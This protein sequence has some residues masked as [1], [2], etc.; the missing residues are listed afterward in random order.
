MVGWTWAQDPVAGQLLVRL[1][2]YVEDEGGSKGLHELF[3]KDYV[4]PVDLAPHDFGMS[5]NYAVFVFNAL[6]MRPL[7][8]MTGLKGPAECLDM[9]GRAKVQVAVVRRP[10]A[11][12]GEGGEDLVGEEPLFVEM[13]AAF[14]IH[15]SHA[16][17]EDGKVIAHFSGWPPNDSESFLGAWGGTA[18][19]FER[20]PPTFLWRLEVDLK[21]KKSELRVAK[22]SKDVCGEHL[23]VRDKVRSEAIPY[24]TTDGTIVLTHNSQVHPEFQTKKCTNLFV[25]SSNLIGDS[26]PPCGYSRLMIEDDGADERDVE[27]YWW[28][29][30]F[31]CGEPI[32]AP[33]A[34]E[35]RGE[36]D[37]YLLG[38]VHDAEKDGAF[39]A[40]F[41]LARELSE[42]PVCEIE[43]P[44]AIP[45]GLHGSW[46]GEGEESSSF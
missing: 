3:G 34:G 30:R 38:M 1:S 21:E 9:D 33:K 36:D 37:G 25:V 45:H 26:S 4:F 29:T 10:G 24:K 41:D 17:E 15:F 5:E 6:T 32:I 42:G 44:F 27:S 20:I 43:C 14:A 12:V 19:E 40:V 23:K 22:G 39:L 16:Y 31:F 35:V 7:N 28:G 11:G 13:D 18:P 46:G 8:F 2:E